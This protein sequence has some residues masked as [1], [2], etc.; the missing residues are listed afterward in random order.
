MVLSMGE[1]GGGGTQSMASSL[2]DISLFSPA[3]PLPRLNAFPPNFFLG[4]QMGS[5]PPPPPHHF[6]RED[7]RV[8]RHC[9]SKSLA[10][11]TEVLP[12][13]NF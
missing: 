2:G 1:W 13:E 10:F 9:C 6:S 7:V 8:R 5:S 4:R 3:V 11:G 12:L